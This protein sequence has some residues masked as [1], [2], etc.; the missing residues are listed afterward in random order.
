LKAEHLHCSG[1]W[2][3]FESRVLTHYSCCRGPFESKV[4]TLAIGGAEYLHITFAVGG[5]FESK[6]LTYDM[7]R[8]ILYE[9]IIVFSSKMWK[10][11]TLETPLGR[12]LNRGG[13]EASTSLASPSTNYWA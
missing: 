10:I 6:I 9:W 8:S 11:I 5:P 12:P 13:D 2:G 7:L 3:S 4:L 1:G